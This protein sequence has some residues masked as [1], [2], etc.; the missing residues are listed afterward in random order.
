MKTTLK[1]LISEIDFNNKDVQTTPSWE[2]LANVLDIVDFYWSSDDRLKCYFIQRW[3]CTDTEVGTRAY[4]LDGEFVALSNQT[5]RKSDETFTFASEKAAAKV[6][7]YITFLANEERSHKIV[8][9]ESDLE[10]ECEDTFTIDFSSQSYTRQDF[11]MV[12]ELKSLEVCICMDALLLS[13]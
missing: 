2:V 6:K 9:Q 7:E 8:L 13:A 5:A 10:E 1:K 11:W 3:L 4:F 12:S